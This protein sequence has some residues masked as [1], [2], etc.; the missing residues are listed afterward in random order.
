MPCGIISGEYEGAL[1]LAGGAQYFTHLDV[2]IDDGSTITVTRASA[3]D[4]LEHV[5]EADIAKANTALGKLTQ[6]SALTMLAW[7]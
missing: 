3:A 6:K 7:T 2:F 5:Q 1:P 4:L